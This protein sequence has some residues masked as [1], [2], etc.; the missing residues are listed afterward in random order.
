MWFITSFHGNQLNFRKQSTRG[1]FANL[2]FVSSW[3]SSDNVL[4]RKTQL[5]PSEEDPAPDSTKWETKA[6]KKRKKSGKS[7]DTPEGKQQNKGKI[8]GHFAPTTPSG[9]TTPS[10]ASKATEDAKSANEPSSPPAPILDASTGKDGSEATEFSTQE[11]NNL[12]GSPN[13]PSGKLLTIPEQEDQIMASPKKPPSVTT[14][15]AGCRLKEV[16][17]LETED[18]EL[19]NLSKDELEEIERK[20]LGN[21]EDPD[22]DSPEGEPKAKKPTWASVAK[23]KVKCFEVLYVHHG[24]DERLPILKEQFFKLFDRMNA[25]II[26]KI[27]DGK[28]VP[29]RVVWH[30]WS[31][32]RGLI[33]TADK[34]TSDFIIG[35]VQETK[36][37]KASF[38]AWRSSEFGHGRLATGHL[39]GNSTKSFSHDEIMKCIISQNS[40]K[41]QYVGV[42]FTDTPHGRVLRFYANKEM[43]TDLLAKR[44]SQG[45]SKVWLK[46]GFSASEFT[47]SKPKKA[48]E[49]ADGAAN[50]APVESSL[51]KATSASSS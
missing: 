12:L 21:G 35:L 1:F 40:L 3:M 6:D 43:W 42:T 10:A 49:E 8:T 46:C 20:E 13:N 27:L 4:G 26:A 14:A 22:G 25:G 51:P 33:A 15:L 47:L 29:D 17:D 37:Q 24:E 32:G 5:N 18:K 39:K 11:I 45:T 31:K 7:G 28:V 34:E 44:E 41:G 50:A 48:A 9:D 36:L 23:P 2:F 30:S 16:D 38:R 19:D